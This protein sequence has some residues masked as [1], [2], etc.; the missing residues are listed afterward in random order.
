[1]APVVKR[2]TRP[3]TLA[4]V[5][6]RAGVNAATV[7]RYFSSPGVVSAA[8]ATRIRV[9]VSD[10]GYTPNLVAGALASERRRLIALLVADLVYPN[11]NEAI[12]TITSGLSLAGSNVMLCIT[13][14]DP[15]RAE[16][17]IQ[18]VL[19]W[20]VDAVLAWAPV[21]RA[22][23][24]LLA[25][26]GTS[27]VQICDPAARPVD[28]GIGFNQAELGIAL[29]RFAHQRGY[30]APHFVATVGNHSERTRDGFVKEWRRLARTLAT[31]QLI[32]TPPSFL[33]GRA[34][35]AHASKLRRRPDLII[36]S[37]DYLA[38]AVI[39]EAQADG[40]RVPE[41]LAV[42]GLGDSP[43][44]QAMRPAIT[45]VDIH[46]HRM[47]PEILRLLETRAR[48][49]SVPR[50]YIDLGFAIIARESA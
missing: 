37:S 49:G 13:G 27:V 19:S 24:E 9:A 34:V 2:R 45:T 3:P 16:Q 48:G 46:T 31:E 30:R 17:L 4:D 7:S 47:A 1:M 21:S 5:A 25:R 28:I 20:R 44:A 35:Y 18:R 38:Q 22:G 43:V 10:L 39:V 33:L 12:E 6:R 14:G 15:E 23:C 29:A 11:F 42:M 50:Q 32:D 40:Q 8:T 26:S 36:C 41:D